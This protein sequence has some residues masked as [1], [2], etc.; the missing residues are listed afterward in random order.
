MGKR[1]RN[2]R[3]V[4]KVDVEDCK[5][6]EE[7]I[8]VLVQHASKDGRRVEQAVHQVPKPR[9]DPPPAFKP[10]PKFGDVQGCTFPN[11]DEPTGEID[12]SER[13]SPFFSFLQ[14]AS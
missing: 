12:N 3:N 7:G 1:K 9:Q 6:R 5:I 11:G 10:A 2:A 13:V 8:P 14:D 4:V